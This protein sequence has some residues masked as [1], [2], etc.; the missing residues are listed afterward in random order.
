MKSYFVEVVVIS[1][2]TVLTSQLPGELGHQEKMIK[3]KSDPGKN[4]TYKFIFNLLSVLPQEILD[5]PEVVYTDSMAV[6]TWEHPGGTVDAFVLQYMLHGGSFNTPMA[7]NVRSFSV[8]GSQTSVGVVNLQP[9]TRY[10]FRVAVQNGNGISAFSPVVVI[11]TNPSPSVKLSLGIV[12]RNSRSSPSIKRG[13][14]AVKS[15]R[16]YSYYYN[17]VS[18]AIREK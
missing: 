13:I 5:H 3:S 18:I 15:A 4:Y 11:T 12:K 17:Q 9:R 8:D 7:S 16:L 14:H 10:Q 1:A 6:V 2:L